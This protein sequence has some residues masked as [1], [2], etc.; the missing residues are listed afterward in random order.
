MEGIICHDAIT[1]DEEA[2]LC[3]LAE[4]DFD[5]KAGDEGH[6]PLTSS[7]ITIQC[8]CTYAAIQVQ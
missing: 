7:E 3:C 2:Y 1:D 6:G 5:E 8:T 4:L